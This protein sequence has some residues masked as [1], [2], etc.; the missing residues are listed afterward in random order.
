MIFTTHDVSQ[1]SSELF[2]RDQV[3]FSEKNEYGASELFRCSDM[4]GVWLNTPLDK[5]YMSGRFGAT[6][7]INDVEF[8]IA[9]QD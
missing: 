1:L 5:W 7:I 4:E 9:M 6:P 3:W 8:L 2:R